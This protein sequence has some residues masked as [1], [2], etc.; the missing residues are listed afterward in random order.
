MKVP[1]PGFGKGGLSDQVPSHNT[2]HDGWGYFYLLN[3]T[4]QFS[5]NFSAKS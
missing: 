5:D 2:I 4:G 3:E 1:I